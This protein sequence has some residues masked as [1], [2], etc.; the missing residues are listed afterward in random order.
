MVNELCKG[1]KGGE[2]MSAFQGLLAM[3]PHVRAVAVGGLPFI[4]NL[5]EGRLTSSMKPW[6]HHLLRRPSQSILQACLICT[7]LAAKH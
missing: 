4:P 7:I 6:G 1:L 3:E 5:S 2:L